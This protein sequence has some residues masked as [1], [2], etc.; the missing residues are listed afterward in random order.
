MRA[1][2]VRTQAV[3]RAR[4]YEVEE[5]CNGA[6]VRFCVDSVAVGLDEEFQVIIEP[7]RVKI[8]AVRARVQQVA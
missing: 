7:D 4:S 5:L 1:R 8:T 6:L 2:R 3:I